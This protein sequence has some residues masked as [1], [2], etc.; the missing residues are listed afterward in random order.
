MN[1]KITYI[2]GTLLSFFI[3]VLLSFGKSTE[4]GGDSVLLYFFNLFLN[5]EFFGLIFKLCIFLFIFSLYQLFFRIK[6]NIMD[7]KALT[8]EQISH[9]AICLSSLQI[10]GIALLISSLVGLYIFFFMKGDGWEVLMAPIGS[11][12][13]YFSFIVLSILFTFIHEKWGIRFKTF[14]VILGILFALVMAYLFIVEEI[15]I[16]ILGI[17]IYKYI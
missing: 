8:G 16:D 10:H 13:T 1:R 3:I 4:G 12:L 14:L 15:L 2:L 6:P 9:P 5:L 17:D 11:F 7:E